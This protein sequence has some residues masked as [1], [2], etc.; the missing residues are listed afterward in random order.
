MSMWWRSCYT[1]IP[2]YIVCIVCFKVSYIVPSLPDLRHGGGKTAFELLKMFIIYY[3]KYLKENNKFTNCY[4]IYYIHE[5][6]PGTLPVFMEAV[7]DGHQTRTFK[8]SPFCYRNI[9][10]W[11]F[12]LRLTSN[13]RFTYSRLHSVVLNRFFSTIKG[14]QLRTGFGCYCPKQTNETNKTTTTNRKE[15]KKRKSIQTFW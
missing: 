12:S 15:R 11:S 14:C 7:Q 10:Y 2:V 3:F 8:N 6:I 1:I 4:N 13:R 9:Y 5:K